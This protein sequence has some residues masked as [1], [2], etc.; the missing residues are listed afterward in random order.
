MSRTKLPML[1][2]L[3]AA[4]S[5][6]PIA[7]SHAATADQAKAFL[8]GAIAHIKDVGREKAF[9]DFSTP[10][11]TYHD[12][13]LY[14]ACYAIDGTN[15]AHGG[16]P[17]FVGKNLMGMK[18]PDGKFVNQEV[19]KAGL[20]G[21]GWVDTRWPNPVSKKIEPKAIYAVGVDANTVCLSGYYK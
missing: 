12:G 4:L 16:N 18:D 21:S 2:A 5:L 7:S 17:A 10:G 8:E 19:I 11:G 3:A 15:L 14:V 6:S 9:A 20:A 13:E 1:A